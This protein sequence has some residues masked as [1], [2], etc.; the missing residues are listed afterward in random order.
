MGGSIS[1]ENTRTLIT[2]PKDLKEKG[3]FIAKCEHRSLS[4]LLVSILSNYIDQHYSLYNLLF[5]SNGQKKDDFDI[6]KFKDI[7]DRML[8]YGSANSGKS[9]ILDSLLKNMYYNELSQ[10]DNSSDN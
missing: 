3:A 1:E 6:N 10:Q 7:S 2:I 9:A 4:N 5:D 8:I